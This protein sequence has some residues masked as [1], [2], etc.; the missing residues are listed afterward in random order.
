V[1]RTLAGDGEEAAH[2]A[3]M[4]RSGSDEAIQMPPRTLSPV[5]GLSEVHALLTHPPRRLPF[6]FA[7]L[8]LWVWTHPGP[9]LPCS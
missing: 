4:A 1:I 6:A 5:P 2:N 8:I 7:M 3:V 9:K